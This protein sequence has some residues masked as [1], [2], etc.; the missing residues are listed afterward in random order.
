MGTIFTTL[1]VLAIPFWGHFKEMGK[2]IIKSL[3]E[4]N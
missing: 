1:I 2:D 3:S 4:N